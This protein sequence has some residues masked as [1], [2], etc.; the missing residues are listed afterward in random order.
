MLARSLLYHWVTTSLCPNFLYFYH[1]LILTPVILFLSLFTCFPKNSLQ[2]ELLAHRPTDSTSIIV[3]TVQLGKF[4]LLT[5]SE[6]ENMVDIGYG[7]YLVSSM[8][9]CPERIPPLVQPHSTQQS[10]CS[11]LPVAPS[12]TRMWLLFVSHHHFLPAFYR[13]KKNSSLT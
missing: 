3:I 2:A 13:H 7:N 1:H 10:Q 12:C 4:L 8:M 5:V 6:A 11:P 9:C